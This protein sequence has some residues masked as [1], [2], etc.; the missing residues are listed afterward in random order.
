[1]IRQ[2]S[3]V[4]IINVKLQIRQRRYHQ[5]SKP[6]NFEFANTATNLT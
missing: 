2:Y 6:P 5:C 3:R 4:A 1:M